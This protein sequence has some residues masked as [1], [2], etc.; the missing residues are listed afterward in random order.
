MKR[1]PN[2]K[3][4]IKN[5]NFKKKDREGVKEIVNI[6]R[7]RGGGHIWSENIESQIDAE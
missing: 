7:D 3:K 2:I 4:K 6:G 1:R 5:K